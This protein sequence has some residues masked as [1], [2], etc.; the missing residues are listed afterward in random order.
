MGKIN[1]D[2]IKS[3]LDTAND[4]FQELKEDSAADKSEKAEKKPESID[5]MLNNAN[6]MMKNI[7]TFTQDKD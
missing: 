7:P 6:E 1:L 5:S 4:S 2:S 3:C